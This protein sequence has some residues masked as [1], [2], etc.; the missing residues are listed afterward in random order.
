MFN[1][2][3]LD[4]KMKE[5]PCKLHEC[6]IVIFGLGLMGGSL[7]L[8]LRGRCRSVIG[9]DPDPV[10]RQIA[11]EMGAVDEAFQLPPDACEVDL[12]ILAAPVL[13]II[14][15]LQDLKNFF[16]SPSV[17]L[18][19]GST[20]RQIITAMQ[21][22]EERF[23]PI[24][25]HPMCGKE[26]P[27][28][29]YAESSLY[30]KAP[31]ALVPLERTSERARNLASELVEQVGAH[32]IW[33]DANVHDL[34]VA[35]T[36][37]LPYLVANALAGSIS[38]DYVGMVGSGF[39]STTRLAG[40]FNPMMLDVLLTNRDHLLKAC[41]DFQL[42]L[43]RLKASLLGNDVSALEDILLYSAQQRRKLTNPSS[44]GDS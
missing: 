17:I 43:D 37:H 27:S 24:G 26:M 18:D 14:N 25:G 10:A 12:I 15:L 3:K 40:S 8:A 35:Y 39:R 32:S 33:M 13:T 20:K 9:I 44:A 23:D 2:K 21:T 36:S 4:K 19:L 1:L 30:Q 28:I 16:S 7:A 38:V 41:G 22:L 42:Q 5:P 34:W 6:K 11:R 29:R 31:F